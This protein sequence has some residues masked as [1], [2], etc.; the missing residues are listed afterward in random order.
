MK[1]NTLTL[2]L[3]AKVSAHVILSEAQAECGELGVVT[4]DNMPPGTDLTKARTCL[5]HPLG[6]ESPALS[7]RKAQCWF[8]K[9]SGCSK[10][11]CWKVCDD[12][13]SFCWVAEDNGSGPWITC[14]TDSQC[15]RSMACGVG[16]CAS[17]GCQ[18]C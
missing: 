8:D 13:N 11:Y 6:L 7:K 5:N 16:N 10:G 18:K 1:F 2:P 9:Y 15:N 17:C 3:I 14:K 12:Y 4:A